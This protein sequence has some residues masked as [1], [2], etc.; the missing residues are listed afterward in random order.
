MKVSFH[1]FLG[2][3]H[4][5]SLVGHSLAREFAKR[6]HALQLCSTNGYEHYPKDLIKYKVEQKDLD[7][8]QDMQLS[9][10]S[11]KNFPH[12][13]SHGEKNRFGIWSFEFDNYFPAGFAKCAKA[14]DKILV[15]SRHT[16]KVFVDGGVPS[17][18]IIV[19]PHGI[20]EEFYS[21]ESIYPLPAKFK[22]KVKILVNIAQPHK[23]KGIPGLLEM[24]GKAFTQKD[25]VVLIFKVVSKKPEQ[26]FEENVA[27][28]L[29]EFKKKYPNAADIFH[30]SHYIEDIS[31]LYRA[32][33]IYF[34]PSKAE[35]F[36]LSPGEGIASNL[37]TITSRA[38][39][40]LDFCND[41]NSLLIDG[42]ME[43]A[44]P[45]MIY[46]R[47]DS[48]PLVKNAQC[49]SPDIDHGIE[50][51]RLS[52]SELPSLKEKFAKASKD[53]H[54]RLTW[55]KVAEQIESMTK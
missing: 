24:Y 47:T 17:D 34:F 53:L 54:S 45:A 49:F 11:M 26:S 50:L 30:I 7:H 19:V 44:D 13:L 41:S 21:G 8:N 52:V 39:G 40:A 23:R 25:N 35:A 15:P 12:Y 22:D 9:Y 38:G 5:W 46:W 2:K 48:D 32:C 29:S 51:L 1:Q 37:V 31:S 27:Q 6:G 33:D 14:A 42:K 18:R 43:R 3:N 55:D 16:E 20:D 10:T 36:S 4:S 28:L